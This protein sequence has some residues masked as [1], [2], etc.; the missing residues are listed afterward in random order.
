MTRESFFSPN[1]HARVPVATLRLADFEVALHQ[2]LNREVRKR[3]ALRT[4]LAK[5][6]FGTGLCAFGVGR[7]E[8]PESSPPSV[9]S[10]RRGAT[11]HWLLS[12]LLPQKEE[13]QRPNLLQWGGKWDGVVWW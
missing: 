4:F 1:T 12:S 7:V 9:V 2:L 13:R 8:S 10:L 11:S 5:T 6:F 3:S